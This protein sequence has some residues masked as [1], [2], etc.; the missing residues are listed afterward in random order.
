MHLLF[1][2]A[3]GLFAGWLT[4]KTMSSEGRDVVMDLVM[5]LAGGMAG[6]FI[7]SATALVQGKMI[8]TDLAAIAG[9]V[10]LTGLARIVAGRREYTATNE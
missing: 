9:G 5:G 3:G 8:F 7:V 6:G 10:I 2:M 4:G 1:W